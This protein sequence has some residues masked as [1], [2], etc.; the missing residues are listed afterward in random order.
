MNP[1][2]KIWWLVIANNRRLG[3]CLATLAEIKAAAGPYCAITA[4]CVEIYA[5]PPKN[6]ES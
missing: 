1:D 4:D 3:R 6:K 2:A 5:P